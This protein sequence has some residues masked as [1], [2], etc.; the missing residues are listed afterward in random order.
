MPMPSDASLAA[1]V[2]FV[3]WWGVWCCH[4]SLLLFH[5]S[6]LPVEHAKDFTCISV[7]SC[8]IVA[9]GFCHLRYLCSGAICWRSPRMVDWSGGGWKEYPWFRC[10]SLEE[11]SDSWRCLRSHWWRRKLLVVFNSLFYRLWN[12]PMPKAP[13]RRFFVPGLT[14]I[15]W[16]FDC[17]LII[18]ALFLFPIKKRP[19]G[20][21]GYELNQ[22]RTSC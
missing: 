21:F 2:I 9:C 5:N 6:F 15:L 19:K 12:Q 20:R 7:P 17:L 16:F 3:T 10:Q 8:H 22:S 13:F 11:K 1:K 14:I 18:D 4:L